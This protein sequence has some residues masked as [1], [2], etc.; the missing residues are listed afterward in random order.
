MKCKL[1]FLMG[2]I[3]FLPF[4]FA[5]LN[6][7]NE[8]EMNFVINESSNQNINLTLNE[9]VEKDFNE[10]NKTEIN[11]TLP[12]TNISNINNE[13]NL[14]FREENLTD[15]VGFNETNLTNETIILEILIF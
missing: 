11:I 15:F 10:T 6:Q 2:L 3:L 14:T 13:T 9:S 8:T 5:E 4:L 7:S 12:N 1:L